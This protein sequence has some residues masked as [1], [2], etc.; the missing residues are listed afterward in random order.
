MNAWGGRK[1]RDNGTMTRAMT[2]IVLALV[3]V[4]VA[5]AQQRECEFDGLATDVVEAFGVTDVT[6]NEQVWGPDITQVMPYARRIYGSVDPDFVLLQGWYESPTNFSELSRDQVVAVLRDSYAK[7]KKKGESTR[8]IVE[9]SDPVS[10]YIWKDIEVAGR[11]YRDLR[12]VILATPTC[13]VAFEIGAFEEIFTDADWSR[14]EGA[15]TTMRKT[16]LANVGPL[17]FAKTP[18]GAAGGQERGSGVSVAGMLSAAV[19]LLGLILAVDMGRLAKGRATGVVVS[20]AGAAFAIVVM[21]LIAGDAAAQAGEY[22]VYLSVVAAV[23]WMVSRKFIRKN[24][25]TS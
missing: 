16:V 13:F 17:T 15:M 6:E 14:F 1:R 18:S 19:G 10:V 22:L 25:S 7:T 5:H 24:K 9:T 11:Q 21:S 4:P 3:F 2:V 12:V 20:V 23:L 8:L